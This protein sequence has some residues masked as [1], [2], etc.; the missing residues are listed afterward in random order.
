MVS[1][2]G[3]RYNRS[4]TAL[5]HCDRS[6]A[7]KETSTDRCSLPA[8]ERPPTVSGGR[9]FTSA[10]AA[11]LLRDVSCRHARAARVWA[12]LAGP[13][14]HPHS[15]PQK[16]PTMSRSDG[17]GG[18]R[19][20]PPRAHSPA[21]A[22]AACP[23]GRPNGASADRSTCGG[24]KGGGGGG[25]GKGARPVAPAAPLPTPVSPAQRVRF[26]LPTRPISTPFVYLLSIHLQIV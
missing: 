16:K 17:D 21:A 3:L 15:G 7:S 18:G 6:Q 13:H 20:S 12:A 2:E 1:P 11:S 4:T 24:G 5:S 8:A 22:P 14:A 10:R 19:A 25:G 23:A 26:F 9:E